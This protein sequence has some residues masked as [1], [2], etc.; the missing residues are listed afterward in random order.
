MTISHSR[1][2][3]NV[4]IDCKRRSPWRTPDQFGSVLAAASAATTA[5][6]TYTPRLKSNRYSSNKIIAPTIDM[7]QPAT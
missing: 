6:P 7:I 4:V 1:G 5:T 3:A 2:R